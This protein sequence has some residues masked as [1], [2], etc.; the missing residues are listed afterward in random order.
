MKIQSNRMRKTKKNRKSSLNNIPVLLPPV[1]SV[2]HESMTALAVIS[3]S[4]CDRGLPFGIV[5]EVKIE[6]LG[7]EN[8]KI[9]YHM[10]NVIM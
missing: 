5:I 1:T 10:S 3:G 7:I 9:E 4:V 8:R 2:V 6:P